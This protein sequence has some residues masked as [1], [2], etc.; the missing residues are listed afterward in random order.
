M[1]HHLPA[2]AHGRGLVILLLPGAK[3]KQ[4]QLVVAARELPLRVDEQAAVVHLAGLVAFKGQGARQ[5][6]DS[7]LPGQLPGPGQQGVILHR[8]GQGHPRPLVNRHQVEVF[9]QQDQLGPLGRRLTQQC[10]GLGQVVIE[11][12]PGDHLQDGNAH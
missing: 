3:A 4:V 5:Q 12:I 1:A 6:P 7:E 10:L 2:R 11:I 8:G 9:G